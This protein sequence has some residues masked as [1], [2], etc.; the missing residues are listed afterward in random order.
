MILLYTYFL[1]SLFIME[2]KMFSFVV[3]LSFVLVNS[4]FL[5]CSG[6]S[7]EL[8]S[9]L[10][11]TVWIYKYNSTKDIIYSDYAK[12]YVFGL[13]TIEIYSLDNELKIKRFEDCL[14][15]HKDGSKIYINGTS[16]YFSIGEHHLFGF[17][18][19][20]FYKTSLKPSDL[21]RL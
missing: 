1:E 20:D 18:N 12:A 3:A 21:V 8:D 5:S 7:E 16:N 13:K 6:E 10:D 4:S 17:Y 9:S 15:Y 2:R 19:K 14:K 11:G